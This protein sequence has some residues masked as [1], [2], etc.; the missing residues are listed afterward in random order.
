MW[1]H[2]QDPETMDWGKLAWV[3]AVVTVVWTGLITLVPE[4]YHH[5]GIVILG[6]LSSGTTFAMRS[7]RTDARTRSEDRPVAGDE[8][9]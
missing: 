4:Q 2:F 3:L 7:R 8:N 1:K 5:A 9:R 6:A